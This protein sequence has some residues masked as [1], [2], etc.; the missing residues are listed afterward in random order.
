VLSYRSGGEEGRQ[1]LD[2]VIDL[3]SGSVLE[4][5]RPSQ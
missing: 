3:P 5:R 1:A 2:V 4:V